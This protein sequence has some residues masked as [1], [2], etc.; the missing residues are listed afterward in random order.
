MQDPN[1]FLAAGWDFLGERAN[2]LCETWQVPVEKGYPELSVFTGYLPPSLPGAGTADDPYVVQTPE[3]LASV[4]YRPAACYRVVSDIDLAG[5]AWSTAIVPGF[6]GAFDAKGHKIRNMTI[7]GCG[8]LGLFGLVTRGA[9]IS[10]LGLEDVNIAGTGWG[11]GAL[12]GALEGDV[13]KSYSTGSIGGTTSVGGLVGENWGYVSESF[14]KA[15]VTGEEGSVGGLVGMNLSF[16]SDSYATGPVS[17]RD[18]VGGLI[19]HSDWMDVWNCYS[20]GPVSGTGDHVGGLVGW[21]DHGTVAKSFWDVAASGS[22]TSAG[23]RGLTT[24]Q[25]QTA[26]TFLDAGWDF[27]GETTNGTKDIWWIDEGKDYPR[28]WWETAQP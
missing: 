18:A 7:S 26:K 11:V 6:A 3:D 25:M 14:S 20:T 2:G 8:L 19:G 12:V 1:T 17:G 24:V 5:I 13:S 4:G 28:L 23:G 16:I 10:G 21:G 27:V 22:D 15:S 9:D